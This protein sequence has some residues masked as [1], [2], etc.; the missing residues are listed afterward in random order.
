M[1]QKE[2]QKL[3][4]NTEIPD[5]IIFKLLQ[6]EGIDEDKNPEPP[7][8][9]ELHEITE[10]SELWWRLRPALMQEWS[11][12]FA[13]EHLKTCPHCQ[14]MYETQSKEDKSPEN[15]LVRARIN[16]YLQSE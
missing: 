9:A 12:Y 2:I 14:E 16:R 1:T 5:E 15:A 6:E 11:A 7:T 13:S 10:C 3:I 8:E 4:E